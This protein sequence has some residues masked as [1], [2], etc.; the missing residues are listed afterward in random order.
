[1][2]LKNS[3]RLSPRISSDKLLLNN[4]SNF[5]VSI[6]IP[7]RN[8]EK[9]IQNCI[10]SLLNQKYLHYEIIIVD[11]NSTDKTLE[12]LRSMKENNPKINVYEA[13]IKPVD[14]IGKNWPC[15]VGYKKSKGDFLFFTDADTI[16]SEYSISNSLNTLLDQKLDVLTAIP[17]LFHPTISVKLVLPILSIF[18]FTRYS[19]LRVNDPKTKL[20]YLF[21][22]FF[23]IRKSVYEEIGTHESVKSEILEDGALGKKLKE[24]GYSLKLFR[25]E[26][27]VGAY[28]A[29][30]FNTLWN[31]LKR[32]MVPIYTTNKKNSI[33]M[34]I[35]IFILMVFPFIVFMCSFV[36]MFII[37]ENTN[38]FSL[39]LL[40]VFNLLS[41]LSIYLTNYFQLRLSHTHNV[42]Y[43]LGTIVGCIIVSISFIWSIITFENKG[44]IKWRDRVYRY[45]T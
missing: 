18:L 28:W 4:A 10:K 27:L 9:Y 42:L 19:P 25:G 14:W 36:E 31:A 40:F 15:H 21:G 29:R 41:V 34:T 23:I 12:I 8:E 33:L 30:D 45:G 2:I 6:I 24:L 26:D 17:K 20:G 44:I 37:K 35:G 13:G 22:S 11:D 5:L 32:L 1:M 39:G 3:F 16:H 7:A 38:N 43:S